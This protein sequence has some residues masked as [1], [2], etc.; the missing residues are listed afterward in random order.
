MDGLFCIPT[1]ISHSDVSD[2]VAI[3]QQ[4]ISAISHKIS[5]QQDESSFSDFP[6]KDCFLFTNNTLVY[7]AT[8]ITQQHVI[9]IELKVAEK[10]CIIMTTCMSDCPVRKR[11]VHYGER[12][13]NFTQWGYNEPLILLSAP[14][15]S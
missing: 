1:I 10:W 2:W 13:P 7:V 4:Y 11:L 12:G 6:V 14:L 15:A 9:P 8:E 5:Q 3:E